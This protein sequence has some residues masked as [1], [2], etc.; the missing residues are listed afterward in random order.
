MAHEMRAFVNKTCFVKITN[1]SYG[2]RH[3]SLLSSKILTDI[4]DI[5]SDWKEGSLST[6]AFDVNKHRISLNELG[7]KLSIQRFEQWYGVSYAIL[8]GSLD[9]DLLLQYNDSPIKL[10][11]TV[12]PEHPVQHFAQSLQVYISM[13]KQQVCL[14]LCQH[15]RRTVERHR[16]PTLLHG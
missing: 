7:K 4:V 1:L 8:R 2:K 11:G 13:G 16:V 14:L 15:S 5:S 10:F 12:Y 6:V 9:R 3:N